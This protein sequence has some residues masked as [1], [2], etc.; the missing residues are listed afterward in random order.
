M[1][2]TEMTKKNSAFLKMHYFFEYLLIYGLVF[3]YLF[4]VNNLNTFFIKNF[5]VKINRKITKRIVAK[6]EVG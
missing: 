4:P 5:S 3:H 1:I 6:N 2:E